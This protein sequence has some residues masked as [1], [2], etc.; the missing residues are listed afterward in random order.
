MALVKDIDLIERLKKNLY[1]LKI[2]YKTISMVTAHN[3]V[4]GDPY[5]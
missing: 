5:C 1:V 4:L 3:L 2:K